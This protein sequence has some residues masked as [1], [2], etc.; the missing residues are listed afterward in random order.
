MIY[1]SILRIW[2][3][4]SP[5]NLSPFIEP[6]GSLPSSKQATT[7]SYNEPYPHALFK[8]RFNVILPFMC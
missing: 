4:L 2:E 5:K 3:Q 6:E 8:I 1:E 7:G